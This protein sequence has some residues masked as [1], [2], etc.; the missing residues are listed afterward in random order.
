M[1][2]TIRRWVGLGLLMTPIGIGCGC[3]TQPETKSV[4]KSERVQTTAPETRAATLSDLTPDQF[5]DLVEAHLEGLGRMQRFEYAEAAQA[6]ETVR[7]IAPG[8]P[9]SGVNLAI[10][11]LNNTGVK[12]EDARK[13]GRSPSAQ[14]FQRELDLL[15]EVIRQ[16]PNN[17]HAYYCRGLILGYVGETAQAHEAFRKVNELDPND[18]TTWY[19]LGATLPDPDRPDFPVAQNKPELILPYFEKAFELNPYFESAAYRLM[20]AYRNQEVTARDPQQKAEAIRKRTEM[21]NLRAQL[22]PK[23]AGNPQGPGE[24][25]AL[26]YGEAGPYATI[27][28]P[29]GIV[30]KP[31]ETDA[32][33]RWNA[34]DLKF[35]LAQG[36]NWATP[37]ELRQHSANAERIAGQFGRPIV[38]F[39]LDNDDLID[40]FLPNAIRDDQGIRDGLFRQR[41]DGG[42]TELPRAL[43]PSGN[44]SDH[45]VTLGAAAADF[46]AD[47][48]N[49]L[50]LTGTR[51]VRLLRNLGNQSFEDVTAQAGLANL[52]Q[53]ALTARWIDLDQDGDL[54]L[55]LV[56]PTLASQL[57]T[58]FRE[59]EQP[60]PSPVILF[61]NDGVPAPLPGNLPKDNWAPKAVAHPETPAEEGLSIAFSRWPGLEEALK[62][63]G[64]PTTLAAFDFDSDRDLDLIVA[65]WDGT[66]YLLRNERLG[67]FLREPIELP[68]GPSRINHLLALD[69]DADGRSDLVAL[70][71][72]GRLRVW[73]NE[74]D[75][76]PGRR[77]P[78]FVEFPTNLRGLS[79]V[80]MIDIDLNGSPDVIGPTDQ[81]PLA[82]RNLG[83]RLIGF[84]VGLDE[85]RSND[86]STSPEQGRDSLETA[87]LVG[88]DLPDLLVWRPGEPPRVFENLGNR[89]NWL[90]LEFAGR[91]KVGFDQ[92]RTN[93][94]GYG[95]KLGVLGPKLN[96]R[97]ETTSLIGATGQSLGPVVLGLGDS[98]K[99][100]LV[101]IT[102][103]DGVLQSELQVAA[104]QRLNL[105]ETNRKTGSC[106]V[107]F[108]WNGTRFEC[109]GDFLGGGGMGYLVAPGIY[110]QPDRDEALLI[111]SDQLKPTR[112]VYRIAVV[113][114]MDEISYLDHFELEVIDHPAEVT[115][116]LDERFAP[117]GPRPT[118][119]VR[120]WR[121]R[122]DPTKAVN[123]Q[124]QEVTDH[125]KSTDR[126]FAGGVKKLG[127]WIGYAEEHAITLDFGNRVRDAWSRVENEPGRRLLL[128]LNGWVEY[129]YSQTNYA[130]ATAG[131]ELKPPVL[132]QQRS[133]GTWETLEPYP[134]Y[135][136]G[137]PRTMS[138]EL[139]PS[140]LAHPFVVRIRTN[141][142]CDWDEAF[143][144]ITE[145][146]PTAEQPALYRSTTLPVMRAWLAARGY[147]REV[148]PDGQPPLLYEYA[149]VDP[150]PFAS[151]R[152]RLTR[153]GEVTELVAR[154]DDQFAVIGPGDEVKLEFDATTLP[155][156]P[157]GWNRTFVLRS[158]GYCKDADPF[159]AGSDTVEPLPWKGMPEFPFIDPITERLRDPAYQRYLDRYQTREIRP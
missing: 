150:A 131:V 33:V 47:G 89:F 136:A 123:S 40:L 128:V 148:S 156:L 79:S 25:F 57:E 157:K 20:L 96:L 65:G 158:V 70:D 22:S 71:H 35:E 83:D 66:P 139:D 24:A 116:G 100:E 98:T 99:A 77:Q 27:I 134:G 102:W 1:S 17:A 81:Q 2:A 28:N 132:E 36:S 129:P 63:S 133:D 51:G 95:A 5:K 7:R 110:G 43:A 106:P 145:P 73:R 60:P 114:P 9:P 97:L 109:L 68:N 26:T 90:A 91:W 121:T 4:P 8:W 16:D 146:A 31:A 44:G 80:R 29:P 153:F 138:V 82:G 56:T 45:G 103:P 86:G 105:I 61:R 85:L 76:T 159:T 19:Q 13:A 84:S 78:N 112:G 10:A 6:F 21:F 118:G 141:M 94:H 46:D 23:T 48:W 107:C 59:G 120:A 32:P 137:L 74:T 42:Y 104:N 67:R 108:T 126:R 115:I 49:D 53:V 127:K 75:S 113:E 30:S 142:E 130:A 140:K 93:P 11:L 125:L 143:L 87:N 111:R 55:V 37:E 144:A 135:P 117:E 50:V 155:E 54:D 15:A 38:A 64:V 92:M 149:Q 147:L 41:P 58:L 34:T 122:I 52:N 152:G 62:P 88:D 154:D 39:D 151:F 12:A 14:D 72:E 18:A 3:G 69:L 119:E 124:G 101:Q